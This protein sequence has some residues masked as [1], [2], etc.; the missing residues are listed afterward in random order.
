MK[1]IFSYFFIINTLII[2]I[3]LTSLST[4]GIKTDKFNNI[5]INKIN[6]VDNNVS[7]DLTSI[8]FKLD[9]K[10][11]S[12]FLETFNPKIKYR[13]VSIPAENIKVYIDFISL[14]K[15]LQI[16]KNKF[17][18]KRTRNRRVKKINCNY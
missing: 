2:I 3:T 14:L 10:E 13:D 1:K 4:I 6:E 9:I 7:I 5:I 8:N 12:L 17:I 15:F 18:F 16:L 11:I